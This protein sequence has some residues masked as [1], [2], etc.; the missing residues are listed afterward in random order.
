MD[1]KNKILENNWTFRGQPLILQPWSPDLDLKKLDVEK[2][3]VWIQLPHLPL[4]CWTPKVLGKIAS[5]IGKPLATDRMTANRERLTYARILVE[6]EIKNDLRYEVRVND[7]GIKFLQ[8]VVYEWRPI[9]CKRCKQLGHSVAGCRMPEQVA[10]VPKE[11]ALVVVET[12]ETHTE[13]AQAQIVMPVETIVVDPV[14]AT[15]VVIEHG[16]VT[17]TATETVITTPVTTKPVEG[18]MRNNTNQKKIMT[19]GQNSKQ[20]QNVGGNKSA[21]KGNVSAK[22]GNA[23]NQ[24]IQKQ[25][26]VSKVNKNHIL[27][28]EAV[29]KSPSVIVNGNQVTV[30]LQPNG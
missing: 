29:V 23:N 22:K 27:N 6:M 11:I 7:M 17:S 19:H 13:V 28:D 15:P 10:W 4:S 18:N 12:V 21:Q 5:C 25:V 8:D 14:A 24:R 20:I 2:V 1:S 26:Q 16:A 9:R 3:P 30:F